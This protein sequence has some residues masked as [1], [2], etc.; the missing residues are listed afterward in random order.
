MVHYMDENGEIHYVNTAVARVPERYM[1]QVR[2]QL[3][4]EEEAQAKEKEAASAANPSGNQANPGDAIPGK[5]KIVLDVLMKPHCRGCMRLFAQLRVNNIF[6]RSHNVESREGRELY[7]QYKDLQLPITI[8]GN[9]AVS[10][11]DILKIKQLLREMET[12][13]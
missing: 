9:Q 1:D 7:E 8:V 5:P 2:P 12:G 13:K 6:F 4:A 11:P 10:G 3:E